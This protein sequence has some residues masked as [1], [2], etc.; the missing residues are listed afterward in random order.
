MRNQY[1]SL[2]V[3]LFALLILGGCSQ[4]TVREQM[5]SLNTQKLDTN[6]RFDALPMGMQGDPGLESGVVELRSGRSFYKAY[7]LPLPHQRMTLQLRTY[8]DKTEI[9][10]GF[11]Y[12]VIELYGLDGKL[13]ET[14]KPQLRFTQLSS[15][16]R[17]SAVPLQLNRN[18]SKFVIRTE[19]KLYGEEASYTTQHQGA[20]WSYSVTPFSKRKPASY[21]PLGKLELLTPDDGF[22]QPFE[23]M[24]GPYWQLSFSRGGETLASAEDYLPNLTLG[25]GPLLSFGYSW[26]ISGRPSSSIRTSLGAS[27]YALSDSGSSTHT[28]SYLATDVLWVESNPVSSIAFGLTGRAVHEYSGNG[29][30]FEY[31][32]AFGPKVAVEIRGSMGVSLGAYLSSLTFDDQDGN[33]TKSN[34][35]G[36]YLMRLY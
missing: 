32:P 22:A 2:L 7:K 13:V 26:N 16:G 14:I 29:K 5:D 12:P 10:D 31:E 35:A 25:G 20:S 3:V 18:I 28:Q 21:L 24:S 36:L 19:P 4:L 17:Y 33:E 1:R 15:K 8:I 27:Y 34:Q 6:Y 11:F 23:K 9:G 30:A